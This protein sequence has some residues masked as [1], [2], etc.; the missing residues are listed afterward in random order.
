MLRNSWLTLLLKCNK[1]LWNLIL[2]TTEISLKI[3]L[4]FIYLYI[5]VF[6]FLSTYW[7]LHKFHNN[8]LLEKLS[9]GWVGRI[10]IGTCC[11]TYHTSRKGLLILLCGR[12]IYTIDLNRIKSHRGSP[13]GISSL[14]KK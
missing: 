12:Q 2:Q 9:R 6:L 14:I 3:L 7:K 1:T 13:K 10:H 11:Y 8:L 4:Q 5:P